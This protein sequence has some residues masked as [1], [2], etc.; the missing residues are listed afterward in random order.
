[1]ASPRPV[2]GVEKQPHLQIG[3]VRVLRR[4]V[5]LDEVATERNVCLRKMLGV[6]VPAEGLDE[7]LRCPLDSATAQNVGIAVG[8]QPRAWV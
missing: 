6:E 5:N 1:M 7:M 3:P 2:R 8:L 4:H